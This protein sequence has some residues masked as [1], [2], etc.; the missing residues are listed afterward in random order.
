MTKKSR[1]SALKK[2]ESIHERMKDVTEADVSEAVSES[3]S[4]TIGASTDTF[5][6]DAFRVSA[7]E[8]RHR[9]RER[10]AGDG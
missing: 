7:P 4:V 10:A 3:G 8:A 5:E 2:L 6:Y 1:A 9:W